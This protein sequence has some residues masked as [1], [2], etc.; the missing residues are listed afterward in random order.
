MIYVEVFPNSGHHYNFVPIAPEILERLPHIKDICDREDQP[1]R[2]INSHWVR[3]RFGKN[4]DVMGVWI[5]VES[6]LG[7]IQRG[8]IYEPRRAATPED[9]V[10]ASSQ[11]PYAA[12][13]ID[14][15]PEERIIKIQV[16]VSRDSQQAVDIAEFCIVWK[17]PAGD[18]IDVDLVVDFGNARTV[19]LALE[20]VPTAGGKLAAICRPIRFLPKGREYER[21]SGKVAEDPLAIVDSWFVLQEPIF[22]N[23]EPTNP[24]FKPSVQLEIVEREV[25]SGLLGQTKTTQQEKFITTRVPQLFVELSHV[26][27]G[28]RAV[29]L[30]AELDLDQGGNYA[31]SS[32]KRYL[33]DNEPMS[34]TSDA[35][36]TMILNEWTAKAWSRATL[37]KL[38][39]SC[40]RFIYPDGVDWLIEEAPN[41]K[42]NPTQRPSASPERPTYPRAEAMTWAALGIIELAYREITSQ[43]WRA[44]NQPYIPRRLRNILVTFPPGWVSQ[45][46]EIYRQKWQKAIDIFALGH[47]RDRRGTALGGDRPRLRME[48]NEAVAAQ[49]PLLFAEIRRTGDL[50][51]N[52]M[53]LYGKGTGRDAQIRVMNVD[54][55]GGTTD[56]SVVQYRDRQHGDGIELETALLFKDSASIAGDALTREVIESVLLPSLGKPFEEISEELEIFEN[57]FSH[58]HERA[59]EK[60]KWSRIVRLVFLPIVHQWYKDITKGQ[61]GDPET[62]EAWAPASKM[63][64]RNTLVD[65][66]S[67][68]E[69]N[70]IC[71]LAGLQEEVMPENQPIEYEPSQIEACVSSCL[72]P[73]F[74]SLAKYVTALECDLVLLSGKPSELPRVKELLI[75]YLPL[76]PQRVLQSKNY[77]VGDWYPLSPDGRISDAKSVAA[78]GAALYLAIQ[79]GLIPNW[80]IGKSYHLQVMTRNTWGAMP[81]QLNP[82]KFSEIYLPSAADTASVDVR[83]GTLIGRKLLPSASR[84]V[85]TYLFR[86]KKQELNTYPAYR[87]LLNV[88]LQRI[89]PEKAEHTESL[90]LIDVKGTMGGKEVWMED[91]ELKLWTLEGDE[92]WTDTGRFEI[93]WP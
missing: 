34:Q 25:A 71:R 67:L 79:N 56:I 53:M 81:T 16:P 33:W 72:A 17:K 7:D 52:W 31:L 91:V 63:E 12:E 80:K 47:L 90:R 65:L 1:W 26:L 49:L 87:I 29:E 35:W 64:H 39:G 48:I 3:G 46:L 73:L 76:L 84:P 86:W 55:G 38:A 20:N 70:E 69:F 66:A 60:A 4:N 18:P 74:R 92:F 59:S 89:P 22:S 10:E 61:Y 15:L 93:K 75:D 36:W 42:A 50:G 23:L 6:N 68:R 83:V 21:F 82:Y 40:M 27:Q 62:G 13:N 44:G 45:E 54:I 85:Q 24:K 19:V 30:L 14:G 37:P 51:E 88:T 57:I 2:P 78:A 11:S 32:P 58:P 41:E 8:S 5:A 77:P 43:N 28:Q 9:G